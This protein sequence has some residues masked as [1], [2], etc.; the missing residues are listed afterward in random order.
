MKFGVPIQIIRYKTL[1]NDPKLEDEATRAWN[2]CLALYYKAGSLPWRLADIDP[3]TCYVGISFYRERL[4][5]EENLM[6][7]LAQIF[8]VSGESLVLKGDKAKIDKKDRQPH[9]TEESAYVLLKK[10]IETFEDHV[11]TKP[12]S[13]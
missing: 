9:L 7:S 8:T 5:G 4:T 10:A 1:S 3:H 6:V 11:K 12:S 2:F 13:S